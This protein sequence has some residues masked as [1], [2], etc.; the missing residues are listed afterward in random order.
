M[1]PENEP[2]GATLSS[3]QREHRA[4]SQGRIREQ[5]KLIISCGAKGYSSPFPTEQRGEG[6]PSYVGLRDGSGLNCTLG[7]H[8]A[9]PAVP[10]A[11]AHALEGSAHLFCLPNSGFIYLLLLE[12]FCKPQPPQHCAVPSK[13]RMGFGLGFWTFFFFL[14]VT[15]LWSRFMGPSHWITHSQTVTAWLPAAH[16]TPVSLSCMSSHKSKASV[17]E[18][19]RVLAQNL[20]PGGGGGPQPHKKHCLSLLINGRGLKAGDL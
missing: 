1:L 3:F 9:V 20:Y 19:K 16:V 10:E 18:R 17:G 13:N 4:V 15:I 14:P 5:G 7:L 8:R 6:I 12:Q 2:L 11:L